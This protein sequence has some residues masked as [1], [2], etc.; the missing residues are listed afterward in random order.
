M[1]TATI[2]YEPIGHTGASVTLTAASGLSLEMEGEFDEEG[3]SVSGS[4]Q[5]TSNRILT[6]GL[7]D[8]ALSEF[9]FRRAR[10]KEKRN[11]AR[12][13]AKVSRDQVLKLTYLIDKSIPTSF[14]TTAWCSKCWNK[15]EH[16]L[17][18]T[19]VGWTKAFLCEACG[20]PTAPC[21]V[22]GCDRFAVRSLRPVAAPAYCAEHRH[23][24]TSFEDVDRQ[25]EDLSEANDLLR[26]RVKNYRSIT[27]VS[28]AVVATAAAGG[29][30]AYVFAPLLGGIV[31]AQ[32]SAMAGTALYGAAATNYG[33]AI[34]GFGSVAV[35]GLGM[36]GGV[37]VL[38]VLG[39]FAGGTMGALTARAYVSEDKSFRIEK[40]ADGSGIPVVV[41]N[42]FLTQGK[43]GW[44]EWE[45]LIRRRYPDS[46]VYRVHWGSK[47]LKA[48][49]AFVQGGA[50]K[51]SARAILMKL[52]LS[53]SK[54]LTKAFG[55]IGFALAMSDLASNPWHTAKSRADKTAVIL[56]D[57]ISRTNQ[58]AFILVGH[59]LGGRIMA[60]TAMM[61]GARNVTT[62]VREV[63]LLGPAISAKLDWHLLNEGVDEFA[64][65]YFSPTDA[66][67]DSLYKG[68]QGGQTALGSTGF[69]GGYKKLKDSKVTVSKGLGGHSEYSEK[70]RLR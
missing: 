55:P 16:T 68:A 40:V 4:D 37:A 36:A 21:V 14:S 25:I 45:P 18:V 38:S 54:G 67:L 42:G 51:L 26:Y 3:P 52:G 58:D 49:S 31:G 64:R 50:G 70:A 33:L 11:M 15:G 60:E 62:P 19:P 12:K 61:L 27:K 48:L 2:E 39:A 17:L 46:P 6:E 8:F 7:W 29:P 56:A 66:V 13:R 69:R 57:V 34:L 47:D 5:L 24:I 53:V 30:L 59:S 63:H 43:A 32:V 1:A 28:A 9:A 23:E 41:A 44:A 22:R 35:G 10:K 65:C 20:I